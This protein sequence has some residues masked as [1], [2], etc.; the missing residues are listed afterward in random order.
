MFYSLRRFWRPPTS[1]D[2][3]TTRSC[4]GCSKF[5][6]NFDARFGS[7]KLVENFPRCA[8]TQPFCSSPVP[9][10]RHGK[11]WHP[12]LFGPKPLSPH[13]LSQLH[14]ICTSRAPIPCTCYNAIV[15]DAE[16]IDVVEKHGKWNILQK[17]KFIFPSPIFIL[18][19][20]H[21]NTKIRININSS[22]FTV[23]KCGDLFNV[24]LSSLYWWRKIVVLSCH[25]LCFFYNGK[26]DEHNTNTTRQQPC[27]Q[28]RGA[29]GLYDAVCCRVVC[30]CW[31]CRCCCCCCCSCWIVC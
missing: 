4:C 2:L 10:V 26:I 27:Y 7:H 14:T 28:R 25:L 29:T 21:L 1:H 23:R 22:W 30:R 31:C 3:T 17:E 12:K 5:E 19:W 8:H 18:M 11:K 13:F 6:P 20:M 15:S 24:C 16:Q 9:K